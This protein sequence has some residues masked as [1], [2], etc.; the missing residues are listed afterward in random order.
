MS[1]QNTDHKKAIQQI[2]DNHF[3][4]AEQ[5]LE[6]VYQTHFA[7]LNT[8]FGRHWRHKRDIPSDL[9]SLPR[10]TSKLFAKKVLKKKTNPLPKSGKVKELEQIV[11][12]KLLDLNDLE[13]KLK[14]Y[15][16]SYQLRFE[17]Q[18][19]EILQQ[20]PSL[21]RETFVRELEVKIEQLTT[22]IEGGRDALM[23]LLAGIVSKIYSDKVTFGSAVAAGQGIATSIYVS[24]LSWFG[25]FWFSLFGSVP[26]WVSAVG[27]SGGILAGAIVAP[28]ITP[29]LE[30]GM[31]KL[32]VRKVLKRTIYAARQKLTNEGL[33]AYDVAGKTA[34]YLQLLPDVLHLGRKIIKV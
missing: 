9:L 26:T 14:N 2:I 24:Q 3:N 15:I 8:I 1:R 13:K 31:N 25:S 5:R 6:N 28:F 12:E 18:F 23:F 32:R 33:D 30:F 11:S 10:H 17:E 34:I 20:V 29:L 21:E 27:V 7:S 19:T 16:E 4:E 22:P